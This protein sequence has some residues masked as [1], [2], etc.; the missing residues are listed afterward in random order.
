MNQN[1]K[2]IFSGGG[3][4]GHIFPAVAIAHE[5]KK[6]HPNAEFLFIGAI[7]RM[8]M[9]KVPAEGFQII[10]LPVQGLKRQFTLQNFKVAYNF[11]KSYFKARKIIKEFNPN[12]AIGTGGYVSLPVLYAAQ[13][14][15]IPTVIWEGNGYAGLANKI[16]AK[17]ASAICT[18]L[19]NMDKFFPSN[20]IHFLGN[21]IRQSILQKVDKIS[22][23]AHFNLSTAKRTVFITG[24]SLGARNINLGIEQALPLLAQNQIQVIWQTGKNFTSNISPN[25]GYIHAFINEMNLAYQ[26]ADV[27]VSRAGAIS[28]SEICALQKPAILIPSPNVTDDHQTK[29]AIALSKENAAILWPDSDYGNLGTTIVELIQNPNLLLALQQNILPFAKPNSTQNIAQLISQFIS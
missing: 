15:N 5:L 21:P 25:Y 19:P 28:I 10:G 6:N 26:A 4:G 23:L 27:V 8:E 20:K 22:A 13:K 14:L 2:F 29:N 18:G 3:T 12:V 9:E 11:I 7:G 1:P 17:N 16:L 24:G